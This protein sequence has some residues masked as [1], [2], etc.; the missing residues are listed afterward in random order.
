MD[1]ARAELERLIGE[2]GDDFA[3][4]SR[5]VGKNASYIQQYIKRGTP[6]RLPEEVRRQLAEYF[7]VPEQRLGGPDPASFVHVPQILVPRYAV[8]VQAGAGALNPFDKPIDHV[9]F[10]ARWLKSLGAADAHSLAIIEVE[11]DSMF[12]TLSDGDDILVDHSPAARRLRDGVFVLRTDD[13]LI[14]K[15]LAVNPAD[16]TV[17]IKSDNERYPDFEG[18]PLDRVDLVARVVTAIK[19]IA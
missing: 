14:V 15:R 7:G 1:D 4:L 19:A 13:A 3:G 16:R 9:A 8:R 12:P 10:D 18:V 11:G 5:L 6:R 17:S 2:R